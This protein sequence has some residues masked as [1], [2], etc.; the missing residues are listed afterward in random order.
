MFVA[1]G[2]SLAPGLLLGASAF[3]AQAVVAVLLMPLFVRGPS[4]RDRALL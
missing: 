2:V 4:G 1:Q 3:L